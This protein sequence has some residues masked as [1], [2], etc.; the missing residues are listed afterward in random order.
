MSQTVRP[1]C[2]P[3]PTAAALVRETARQ[4]FVEGFPPSLD[5]QAQLTDL[6]AYR[7]AKCPACRSRMAA[8]P[9]YRPGAGGY[10]LVL[11]CNACGAGETA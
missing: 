10:R 1:Q 6:S 8:K 5:R 3:I 11:T 7:R 9:Y 4:G 2:A